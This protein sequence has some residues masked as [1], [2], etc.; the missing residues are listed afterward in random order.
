MGEKCRRERQESNGKRR[1]GRRKE[2]KRKRGGKEERKN[3]QW[4]TS[5]AKYRVI[6]D[7]RC[8]RVAMN[9]PLTFRSE[10]YSHQL[11]SRSVLVIGST[12]L[13]Y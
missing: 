13:E 1:K 10:A 6:T 12:L 11:D 2:S 9:D 3:E 7:A 5:H 8:K 4:L